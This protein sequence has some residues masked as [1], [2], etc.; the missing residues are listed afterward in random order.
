MCFGPGGGAEDATAVATV[1]VAGGDFHHF[2]QQ[3]V[4]EGGGVEAKLDEAAVVHDQIVFNSLVA[5]VWQ[6]VDLSAGEGG[7]LLG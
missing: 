5:G 1:G 4:I 6:V 7:H 3:A 2:L